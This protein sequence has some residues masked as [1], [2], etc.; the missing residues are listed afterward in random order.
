MTENSQNDKFGAFNSANDSMKPVGVEKPM[1]KSNSEYGADISG[2]AYGSN[3]TDD[4]WQ[5]SNEMKISD[6]L[7]ADIFAKPAYSAP[8][9]VQKPEI[10]PNP[11]PAPI[12]RQVITPNVGSN[13]PLNDLAKF[14][15]AANKEGAEKRSRQQSSTREIG[16][17]T[18]CSGSKIII[19]T[20]ASNPT[21]LNSDIWAVGQMISVK[22]IHARVVVMI[23]DIRTEKVS[24]Q[25]EQSNVVIV[26]GDIL[27]EV[28]ESPAGLIFKRG[29]RQYP[30]MGSIAHRMRG[31]DLECIF[32]L[33]SKK[34]IEVGS[35]SQ[36]DHLP[37]YVAVDDILSRH[38][39]IVG[40]TGVGKS[41]AVSLLILRALEAEENLRVLV[42]DPHNEFSYSFGDK[43]QVL[44]ASNL[45]L[46][47]WMLNFEELE[48]VIFR[49]R[50]VPEESDILREFVLIAKTERMNSVVRENPDRKYEASSI[51]VDTS[52]PY[53]MSDILRQIDDMI[54]HLEPKF[55]RHHLRN[56]KVQIELIENNP[57]YA[58]MFG[59]T[60]R[61]DNFGSIISKIFR[62]PANGKPLTS[63]SLAGLPNEVVNCVASVLARMA[64]DV[65]R[66]SE[67][68]VKVLLVCEEAHRYV[69]SD[70]KLGFVP[71]RL[72]I[73]RIA[74][75]GRKYGC[76]VA[77]VTQRPGELDPTILSQCS[78]VFA[79]R[80]SNENDQ[81]IIR[82]AMGDASSGVISFLS[83]LDNREAI[84]FGEGVPVPMRL[85]F[86]DND[87]GR[88]RNIELQEGYL[89]PKKA[90]AIDM[91]AMVQS[92]R[93]IIDD[94]NT[95]Q[96]AL[97]KKETKP[98]DNTLRSSIRRAPVNPNSIKEPL[99][100][101][102]MPAFPTQNFLPNKN[103]ANPLN[104]LGLRSGGGL[105]NNASAKLREQVLGPKDN[106]PKNKNWF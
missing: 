8:E 82:V 31:Q 37:A 68:A 43:A 59:R 101:D 36:D 38:V 67:G 32:D 100:T 19:T 104:E 79:M 2:G 64:F 53:R 66:A 44:D 91:R 62:L 56:L 63:V 29:L 70:P 22:T 42:L 41:C 58:F 51:N 49:G 89:R 54:G 45:E 77:V 86:A 34:K 74:K 15:H 75:E 106:A 65:A 83:A 33:G 102:K 13:H 103:G 98:V 105:S 55:T 84:A 88:N 87:I 90:D 11:M 47:F 3:G 50:A 35:I 78:T 25:D 97:E 30:P 4:D 26:N 17:V 99:V 71:T 39:A 73:A 94:M 23:Q 85:R 40:T 46:P 7:P 61:E 20:E 18:S 21:L 72:A 80:L 95:L 93:G 60:S 52:V 76:A 57:R 14:Q 81:E 92:M 48:D 9:R 12:P 69:P 24:W 6:I 96:E 28:Y 16:F 1:F 10:A 27:G 5:L